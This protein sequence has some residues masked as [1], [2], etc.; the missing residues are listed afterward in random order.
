MFKELLGA[1]KVPAAAGVGGDFEKSFK[2]MQQNLVDT[3][4]KFAGSG[5]KGFD[6]AGEI[7]LGAVPRQP[8]RHTGRDEHQRCQGAGAFGPGRQGQAVE[9]EEHEGRRDEV[10]DRVAPSLL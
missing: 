5:M 10:K 3:M 4:R 7:D 1:V 9:A 8:G 2:A 6:D